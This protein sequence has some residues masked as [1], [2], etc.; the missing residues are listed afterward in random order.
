MIVYTLGVVVAIMSL[1]C[2]TLGAFHLVPK[3]NWVSLGLA[4]LTLILLALLGMQ[5]SYATS[6]SAYSFMN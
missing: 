4:F 2:F 3:I 5:I 6:S 1:I